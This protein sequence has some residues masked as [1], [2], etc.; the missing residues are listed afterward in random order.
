L[1]ISVPKVN[2]G[3]SKHRR[4]TP[5]KSAPIRPSKRELAVGL[6]SLN[7]LWKKGLLP[8][9]L[10]R[11]FLLTWFAFANG[12]ISR[13]SGMMGFDRNQ[14]INVFGLEKLGRKTYRLRKNWQNIRTRNPAEP[15]DKS[16]FRFYCRLG[17]KPMFSHLENKNIAKLWLMGF[18]F[19]AL[20]PHYVLWAFREGMTRE[21]VSEKL[22]RSQRSI[23]RVRYSNIQ[24]GSLGQTWLYPLKPNLKE[25]YPGYASHRKN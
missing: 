19:K 1:E 5:G 20:K 8:K 25:W 23:H 24:E 3:Y 7:G 13:Q 14:L 4:F 10:K 18:P 12:N 21:Q 17:I 11:H 15:F 16:F 6:Q 2:K 22:G 9:D